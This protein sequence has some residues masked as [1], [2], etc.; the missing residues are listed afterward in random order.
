MGNAIKY[1]PGGGRVF[2]GVTAEDGRAT[3]SVADQGLGIAPEEQL[4]IFEPFRRGARH[5][6]IPGMGLGLSVARR[7]VEAHGG[8]LD[9]ESAPGA[10]AVFRVRLPLTA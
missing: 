9:V 8:A 7:I 2:V 1:S 10:G 5:E 3:L 4:L 6:G